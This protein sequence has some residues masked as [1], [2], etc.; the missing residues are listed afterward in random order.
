MNNE[1]VV[2]IGAILAILNAGLALVIGFGA[3]FTAEQSALIVGFANAVL[4]VVF[5]V[6]Q[7]S[8]VT[9]VENLLDGGH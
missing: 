7:R 9:P 3:D 4:A 1:P 6:W 5:A 2:S 8:K